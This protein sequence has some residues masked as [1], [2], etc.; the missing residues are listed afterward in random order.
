MAASPQPHT[1]LNLST[2]VP[3]GSAP[4]G[5]QQ[6]AK[7]R[8]GAEQSRCTWRS[9]TTCC[10]QHSSDLGQHTANKDSRL[11]S[12]GLLSLQGSAM[13]ILCSQPRSRHA[14]AS[15][16]HSSPCCILPAG[17]TDGAVRCLSAAAQSQAAVSAQRGW[18]KPTQQQQEN[19]IRAHLFNR[20]QLLRT[21]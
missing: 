8:V 11:Q 12:T 7:Q 14:P 2:A 15:R 20:R 9:S 13:H 5:G 21:I 6:A 3:P 16:A 17:L 18:S 10:S 19:I 4:L 1:L